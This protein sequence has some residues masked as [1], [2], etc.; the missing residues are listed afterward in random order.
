MT[1]SH[2][3][4]PI[5]MLHKYRSMGDIES[6]DISRRS[7][8]S[9]YEASKYEIEEPSPLPSPHHPFSSHPTQPIPTSKKEKTARQDSATKK[10]NDITNFSFAV[11]STEIIAS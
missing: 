11:D 3:S 9:D 4:S 7:Y 6:P 8:H 2:G 5:H 10:T 1:P